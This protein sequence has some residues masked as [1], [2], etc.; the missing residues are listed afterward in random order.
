MT[1]MV[2]CM[3]VE[4][5]TIKLHPP[6]YASLNLKIKNKPCYKIHPRINK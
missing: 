3:I 6:K 4:V 5:Y 1:E 2:N